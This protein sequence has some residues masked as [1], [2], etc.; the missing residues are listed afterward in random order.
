MAMNCSAGMERHDKG[1]ARQ[2]AITGRSA[3]I[4]IR[5][6]AQVAASGPGGAGT[7]ASPKGSLM[8]V[9]AVRPSSSRTAATRPLRLA[10]ARSMG[11]IIF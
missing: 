10:E 4:C 3:F 11:M 9:C 2:R 7:V 6:L 5:S 1:A 8:A